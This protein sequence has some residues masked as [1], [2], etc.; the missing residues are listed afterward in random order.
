MRPRVT[1]GVSVGTRVGA[2]FLA[3]KRSG[4]GA[5]LPDQSFHHRFRVYRFAVRPVRSRNGKAVDRLPA[6]PTLALREAIEPITA[7]C[8]AAIFP[9]LE[10]LIG[11][12]QQHRRHSRMA[13]KRLPLRRKPEREQTR[14]RERPA[15]N[16]RRRQVRHIC[17]V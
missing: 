7:V 11:V 8:R 14:A 13:R 5:S 12:H 15:S 17:H 2:A 16:Q 6:Q 4:G 10:R 3:H 9:E 1:P